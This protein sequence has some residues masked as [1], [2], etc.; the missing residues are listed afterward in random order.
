MCLK[1]TISGYYFMYKHKQLNSGS[2][3]Y[4]L[5]LKLMLA[6]V[7]EILR[8]FYKPNFLLKNWAFF[9]KT[10]KVKIYIYI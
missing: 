3:F 4:N 7:I 9:Q 8:Y 1:A 5:T 6:Q 10:V 2:P